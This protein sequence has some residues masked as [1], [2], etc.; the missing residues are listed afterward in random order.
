MNKLPEPFTC[1]HC[2]EPF[3]NTLLFYTAISLSRK[4]TR[5]LEPKVQRLC[6]NLL[7]L[8]YT[9]NII[10]VDQSKQLESYVLFES[11]KSITEIICD[12]VSH[13]GK[14]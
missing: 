11:A 12:S 10:N 1:T 9:I 7:Q 2:C 8:F 5:A 4:V 14:K 3:V 13:E 6:S